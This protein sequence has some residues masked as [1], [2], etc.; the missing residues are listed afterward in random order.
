MFHMPDIGQKCASNFFKIFCLQLCAKCYICPISVKCFTTNCAL[1]SLVYPTGGAFAWTTRTLKSYAQLH[2]EL[3]Q[4]LTRRSVLVSV[5]FAMC[6]THWTTFLSLGLW[7][8]SF[9]LGAGGFLTLRSN[10]ISGLVLITSKSFTSLC[11]VM[12][13]C[14]YTFLCHC[15]QLLRC[16]NCMSAKLG[17]LFHC[18]KSALLGDSG[19]VDWEVYEKVDLTEQE[20][21]R[22][23]QGS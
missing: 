13:V 10:C 9:V 6:A 2:F 23:R 4:P 17:T 19:R 20:Y 14:D 7:N 11:S 18:P 5:L 16:P 15:M 1:L 21:R 8:I 3:L 22:V 12:F